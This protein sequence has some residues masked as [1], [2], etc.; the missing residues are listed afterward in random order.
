L[1]WLREEDSKNNQFMFDRGEISAVSYYD[2]LKELSKTKYDNEN[3]RIDANIALIKQ[4]YDNQLELAGQNA[5]AIDAINKARTLKIQ[6]EEE[7]RLGIK[8]KYASDIVETE[9]KMIADINAIYQSS[10][11]LGVWKEFLNQMYAETQKKGEAILGLFKGIASDMKSSLS[12]LFYD[13]SKG[14]IDPDKKSKL[15]NIDTQMANLNAETEDLRLKREQIS[16]NEALT[17]SERTAL[18]AALDARQKQIDAQKELLKAQQ[19]AVNNSKDL[20][21]VFQSFLDSITKKMFDFM[22]DQMV[23]DFFALLSGKS[24]EGKTDTGKT[25][26]V[27]IVK[28]W[29]D[30]VKGL[31]TDM[32]TSATDGMAECSD[33]VQSGMGSMLEDID[34]K[35]VG[36]VEGFSKIWSNVWDSTTTWLGALG[37]S[38]S[39]YLKDLWEAVSGFLAQ[40]RAA[41]GGSGGGAGGAGGGAGEGNP[42]GTGEGSYW[43]SGGKVGNRQGG[44]TKR[45]PTSL[46]QYAPRLH[47]GLRA[48]EYPAILQRGETVIPAGQSESPQIGVFVNVQNRTGLGVVARSGNLK[49]LNNGKT[50]TKNIILDLMSTDYGFRGAMG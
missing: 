41:W 28:T 45:F 38:V 29:S 34:G 2:K 16:A 17:E 48:D 10:G 4:D 5:S 36:I 33:A 19:D 9:K 22:A 8:R 50:Q 42:W 25:S 11:T 46:F 39:E 47:G 44:V 15:A 35:G 23:N 26:F 20:G 27:E 49:K 21:E 13:M 1:E 24:P 43:H 3:S 7:K 32:K 40:L 31:F 37:E 30:K 6:E 14:N 12:G 18:N